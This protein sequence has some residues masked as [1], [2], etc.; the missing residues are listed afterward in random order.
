MQRGHALT[1]VDVRDGSATVNSR[2]VYC[3]A[4]IYRMADTARPYVWDETNSARIP[5]QIISREGISSGRPPPLRRHPAFG[6]RSAGDLSRA[7]RQ[8]VFS[9]GRIFF[10]QEE[11]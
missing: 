10:P 4:V 5:K 8:I 9:D 6:S 3:P 1:H 11:R 7:A 2:A